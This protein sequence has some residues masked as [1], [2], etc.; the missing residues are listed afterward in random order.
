[1][2]ST[3][4][5]AWAQF[6]TRM[7][8]QTKAKKDKKKKSVKKKELS[9]KPLP[10]TNL[11]R[12]VNRNTI[13]K[14]AWLCGF[15]C[16]LVV[17]F[18]APILVAIPTKEWWFRLMFTFSSSSFSSSLLYSLF[19]LFG[20]GQSVGNNEHTTAKCL[21][22]FLVLTNNNTH[23]LYR[24]LL[25]ALHCFIYLSERAYIHAWQSTTHST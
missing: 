16:D 17:W 2:H 1:M 11:T 22:S 21:P 3:I 18:I 10:W 12:S 25:C 5:L 7:L 15:W 20:P 24:N 6:Y 19:L 13:R 4:L 14:Y 9:S 23:K 8:D